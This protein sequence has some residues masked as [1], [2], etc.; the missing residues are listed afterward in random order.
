MALLV[1]SLQRNVLS[2]QE[3]YNDL[4][5]RGE[6]FTLTP[7]ASVILEKSLPDGTG[8]ISWTDVKG[9]PHTSYIAQK[10]L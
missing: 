7:R 9:K 5:S 1:M 2:A 10:D 8:I 4:E 6:A 3:L